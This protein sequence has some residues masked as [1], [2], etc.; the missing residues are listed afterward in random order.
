[1]GIG[2]GK[3]RGVLRRGFWPLPFD[4]AEREMTTEGLLGMPGMSCCRQML[5]NASEVICE[6][7]DELSTVGATN[8]LQ[9]E[10]IE[11]EKEKRDL[12]PTPPIERKF[13]ENQEKKDHQKARVRVRARESR[14]NQK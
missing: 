12:P 4:L 10:K 6:L 14:K 3:N 13:R 8:E 1:V 11:G 9:K 2:G 5:V 7:C